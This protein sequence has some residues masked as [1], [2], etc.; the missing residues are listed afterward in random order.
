LVNV[1][2]D[3]SPPDVVIDGLVMMPELPV[4]LETPEVDIADSLPPS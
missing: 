3:V 2:L 1:E 4:V